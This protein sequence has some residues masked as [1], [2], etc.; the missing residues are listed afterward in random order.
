MMEGAIEEEKDIESIKEEDVEQWYS[1]DEEVMIPTVRW[2]RNKETGDIESNATV[3][4][5]DDG[6]YSFYVGE[7]CFDLTNHEANTPD[8]F[9]MYTKNAEFYQVKKLN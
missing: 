9:F 7:H 8:T 4:Q 5:W 1:S 6:T 2:R 3:V